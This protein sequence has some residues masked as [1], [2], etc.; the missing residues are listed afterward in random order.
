MLKVRMVGAAAAVAVI[1]VLGTSAA[2]ADVRK[3]EGKLFGISQKLNVGVGKALSRCS[4]AV[5]GKGASISTANAC[6]KQL[7]KVFNIGGNP[8]KGTIAKA[9]AGVDKLFVPGREV[10]TSEDLA[11]LGHLESGVN[12]PGTD[13]QDF[14]AS[15]LVVRAVDLASNE[16]FANVADFQD[17]IDDVLALTDCDAMERP[18]LCTFAAAQNPDCRVH[19]CTLS[20]ASSLTSYQANGGADPASLQTRSISLKFCQTAA[21]LLELPLD[22]SSDYRVLF[23]DAARTLRP[24]PLSIGLNRTICIDQVRAQG[25]C[26]C[27]GNSVPFVPSTCLDARVNNNGGVCSGS[28]EFCLTDAQCPRRETCSSSG[29]DACGASLADASL[30]LSCTQPDGAACEDGGGTRCIDGKTLGRCHAGTYQGAP[31][32][33]FGGASGAGSCMLLSTIAVRVLPP[34]VCKNGLGDTLGVCTTTCNGGPCAADGQCAG[35]GGTQCVD[36]KGPDGVAC[37]LD[38]LVEALPATTV[39]LSTGSSSSSMY[40]MVLTQ[41]TCSVASP[42]VGMGCSTDGDCFGGTCSAVVRTN[43]PSVNNTRTVG[44][45][46]GLSCNQY[47]SSSLAGFR[48]VGSFPTVNMMAVNDA[49][50]TLEL[51]CN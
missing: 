17:T 40:D 36:S 27:D 15:A 48:M 49:L 3:C 10:C 26:D 7:A 28:G 51:T 11:K 37:T 35:F 43:P 2:S 13:P 24:A 22:L 6:E 32:K 47:D 25:W 31:V 5:R 20:A 21:S 9:I 44:P 30:P 39:A 38:D 8:G 34:A 42:N 4:L 45:G 19:S 14:L 1:G 18:N 50:T 12:A 33:T 41:G 29:F 46:V 16:M 23:S